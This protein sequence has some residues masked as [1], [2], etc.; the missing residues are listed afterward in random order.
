M[1]ISTAAAELKAIGDQN[2]SGELFPQTLTLINEDYPEFDNEQKLSILALV[3]DA[4]NYD[5][6]EKLE[7][8]VTA[9]ASFTLKTKRMQDVVHDLLK[10]SQRNIFITGYSISDFIS[11]F[12]DEIVTKSQKGVFV[13]IYINNIENQNAIDKLLR[14]KGRFLQI[15]NYTN[16]DDKMA[17]LHAKV[18]SIDSQKSLISSANLSYHGLSGNIE[19]G[20]L[21]YS[22]RIARQ[23]DELFQ[24]LVFQKVFKL[25]N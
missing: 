25:L 18:I 11:E 3:L 17:A 15:Y 6:Q 21:I 1:L 16:K 22:K 12:I 14:Y 4:L 5:R 20:S 2:L 7:L 8:I 19:V 13:K 10:E 9:P 23:L 24:Q